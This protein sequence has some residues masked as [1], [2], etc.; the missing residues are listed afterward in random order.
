MVNINKHSDIWWLINLNFV[1]M[2]AWIYWLSSGPFILP[3]YTSW[4]MGLC[5]LPCIMVEWWAPVYCIMCAG[6]HW[7]SG[8]P[9]HIAWMVFA[10]VYCLSW[11]PVYCLNIVCEYWLNSG[12]LS[13]IWILPMNTNW[14]VG[15]WIL[16]DVCLSIL[17]EYI[18]KIPSVC[19]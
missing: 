15:P 5:I 2:F 1:W 11:G 14:M 19:F 16:N 6:V 18:F 3:L 4:V 8:G 13:I 7:L 9:L 10:Q 12:P 17:A